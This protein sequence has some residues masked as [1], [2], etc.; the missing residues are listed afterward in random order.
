MV[1][2]CPGGGGAGKTTQTKKPGF[3]GFVPRLRRRALFGGANVGR[4][5]AL[6]PGGH[7]E[8]DALV[9]LERLETLALDRGEM[10]EEVLATAVRRDETETL[11]VVEPLHG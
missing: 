5:L 3:P 4:L 11:G 6:G 10:C 1:E 2:V 7:V 9:L 8:R